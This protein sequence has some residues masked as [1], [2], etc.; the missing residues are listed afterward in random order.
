MLFKIRQILQVGIGHTLV[1]YKDKLPGK[2]RRDLVQRL[3]RIHWFERPVVKIYEQTQDIQSKLGLNQLSLV[4]DG[5]WCC[6]CENDG[7]GNHVHFSIE[8]I[9]SDCS[10]LQDDSSN[11][12]LDEVLGFYTC[13]NR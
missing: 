13:I 5:Y 1:P 4:V 6:E 9:C 3:R 7:Y 11:A 8:D 10:S 12:T 2:L